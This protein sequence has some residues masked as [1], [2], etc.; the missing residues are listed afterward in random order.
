VVI[1]VL[2]YTKVVKG[3]TRTW[4]IL[5][6][7]RGKAM[8]FQVTGTHVWY[9]YICKREVW[10]MIHQ[11]E[12]NQDDENMQM[13]KAIGEHSYKRAKKEIDLGNAKLDL[14]RT[15]NG[16]VVVGEVK[17]SSRFVESA[18]KQLLFYLLQLKEMGIEA[19]GELLIPEEKK[20]I[21]ILLDEAS[22]KEIIATIAKIEQIA[23]AAKPPEPV[24]N[25]YCRKCA[26]SEFCWA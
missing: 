8:E 10:L 26:Y 20:R 7:V 9:Y 2:Y 22:E 19:R 5:S 11:L 23:T 14:I 3:R 18:S 6:V 24:K 16:Q 1:Y 4:I 13:G 25:K 15:E 21:D 12:A 17:K